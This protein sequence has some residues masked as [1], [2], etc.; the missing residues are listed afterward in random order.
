RGNEVEAAYF[1]EAGKPVQSIDGYAA[2]RN[3]KAL[4]ASSGAPLLEPPGGAAWLWLVLDRRRRMEQGSASGVP[5]GDS[6]GKGDWKGGGAPRIE[7]HGGTRHAY[8]GEHGLVGA[9]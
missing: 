7:L 4:F 6:L 2:D 9:L 8:R 3:S 5:W 1:D